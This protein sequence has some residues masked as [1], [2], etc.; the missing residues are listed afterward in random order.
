[1]SINTAEARS[2]FR[3]SIDQVFQDK[4]PPLMPFASLAK[5]T[6]TSAKEVG[7]EVRRFLEK[8]AA[9][10][11]RGGEGQLNNWGN[12]TLK[13]STPPY[14]HE[15]FDITE[16]QHYDR[17]FGSS[18]ET[19]DGNILDA[20]IDQSAEKL[21]L[22]GD[23]I[24]RKLEVDWSAIMKS[25]ILVSSHAGTF[26]FNRLSSSKE[27]IGGVYGATRYWDG[28]A[29]QILNDLARGAKFIRSTGKARVSTMIPCV[30]GANVLNAVLSSSEIKDQLSINNT[31]FDRVRIQMPE[32]LDSG[33]TMHGVIAAGNYTFV[34]LGYTETYD[35]ESETGVNYWDDDYLVMMPPKPV[36]T[37]K[38][39]GV[40]AIKRDLGNAEFSE[41]IQF[42]DGK[43]T[44][45]NFID[46]RAKAHVFEISSAFLPVPTAIDQLWTIKATN[47]NG[48]QQ[49]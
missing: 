11:P 31:Q 39:A 10:Q 34:L 37:T 40:P 48:G 13:L 4:L 29:P 8:V 2:I 42:M 1:M 20:I 21:S 46:N 27:D 18:G 22:L 43:F 19:I 44:T 28:S 32:F 12:S 5:E 41:F 23:K 49:G 45:D 3:L 9:D 47:G 30:L 38:Y 36:L 25:G 16:I 15:Y 33:F 6:T 24:M 26:D 14:Y 7:W 17:L 35:A